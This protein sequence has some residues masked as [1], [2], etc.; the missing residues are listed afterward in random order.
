M[1]KVVNCMI[2]AIGLVGC[3]REAYT[4]YSCS[5]NAGSKSTMILKQAKMQF[6]D[7]EYDYCGSLGPKSYFDLKCPLQI[8]DADASFI[9][10]SGKLVSNTSEFQCNAL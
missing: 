10:S 9:N 7:R 5:D 6:Q 4:T 8:Q 3:G 2:F 1:N